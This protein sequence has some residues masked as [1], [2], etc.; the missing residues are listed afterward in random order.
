MGTESIGT[1]WNV[2]PGWAITDSPDLRIKGALNKDQEGAEVRGKKRRRSS[3]VECLKID[4]NPGL[5]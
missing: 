3:T 1:N 2:A 5:I 4:I